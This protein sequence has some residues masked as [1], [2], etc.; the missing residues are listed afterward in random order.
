MILNE[1]QR[2]VAQLIILGN[3]DT[4]VISEKLGL[5]VQTVNRIKRELEEL[6]TNLYKVEEQLSIKFNEITKTD[7]DVE[8]I[9][10]VFLK[11]GD[12]NG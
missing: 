10:N 3:K 12:L 5:T 9:K 4:N 6:F 7:S 11:R 8:L 2:K 1:N